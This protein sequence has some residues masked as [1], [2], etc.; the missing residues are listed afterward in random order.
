MNLEPTINPF[1]RYA[2]KQERRI[3]RFLRHITRKGKLEI[4][5]QIQAFMK[6]NLVILSLWLEAK[7]KGYKHLR[8]SRRKKMYANAAKIAAKFEEFAGQHQIEDAALKM[9]LKNL[10]FRIGDKDLPKLRYLRQIMDFLHPGRNFEYLEGASFG[11]LLTDIEKNKMIGDCNQITTFYVF[12]YAQKYSLADLQIKLPKNHVCL[13]FHGIDIE[14]T[15]GTWQRYKEFQYILPVV[16]LVSTNLLDVSDIRDKTVEIEPMEFLKG[17]KLAFN[18]SS[19][20]EI[21]E[22]NLKAAY[23]NVAVNALKNSNF[24]TAEYFF[25][26][27]GNREALKSVYHNA[28]LY[29]V[30][31]KN[32]TRAK[33]YSSKATDPDLRKYVDEKEAFYY[34]DKD[35]T[36]KARQLFQRIGNQQMVKACYG[37][38]F[39]QVQKRV[40][41]VKTLQQMR[42]HKADYRRMLNLA[43]KMNDSKLAAQVRKILNKI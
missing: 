1:S 37:K 28:V 16:E 42:A 5:K 36:T 14:A 22:K 2:D 31:K 4:E 32:F 7:F 29:Y 23:N 8:R 20:R 21:V 27:V 10:G 24:K 19:H 26:Q 3:D 30:K 34:F 15:N 39:N 12:L 25:G 6:Q 38:E 9:E 41:N 40:Q 43:N 33:Y 13:H 18:L 11:K 17:A 35:R